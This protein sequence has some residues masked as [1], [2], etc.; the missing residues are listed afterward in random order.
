[1]P[2]IGQGLGSEWLLLLFTKGVARGIVFNFLLIRLQNEVVVYAQLSV[3][4]IYNKILWRLDH[5]HHV[6]ID[7]D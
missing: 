3:V 1:M 6:A 7:N 5:S 4:P 2:I